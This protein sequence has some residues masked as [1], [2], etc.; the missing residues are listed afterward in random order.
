MNPDD[1]RSLRP[2]ESAQQHGPL[3]VMVVRGVDGAGGGADQIILRNAER[4]DPAQ[5]RMSLCFLRH[6]DDHE[7]DFDRRA[8]ALQLDYHEVRHR[9]ACDTRVWAQL[10]QLAEALQPQLIHSHEYKSNFYATCLA[11]HLGVPRLATAHGWTGD[12]WRERAVYY[13]GDKRL[14]R[15]FSGVIA[16]SDEIRQEL[17]RTG[18][19]AERIRVLLNGVDPEQYRRQSDTRRRVRG[20]LGLSDNH[21]VLGAVGRV[22]RQKR[23]DLLL[24]AFGDLRRDH[25][26]ARLVIAGEGSLLNALGAD[27]RRRGWTQIVHLLGHCPQML[28]TYQA[29]DVLVQSSDYEGTPTVIVEAMALEIPVVATDVGGTSQLITHDQH[30]LLVPRRRP[31]LLAQAIRQTLSDAQATA[32]RVAAA[33]HR[34]ETELNFARRLVKLQDIYRELVARGKLGIA[35]PD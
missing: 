10:R 28:Q 31:D 12:S 4:I 1:S 9:G 13:P 25:V 30:G 19:P 33:R 34:V 21:L 2:N 15:Y 7:F 17:I 29:F 14:L 24:D 23:F 11:R 16:V 22:E 32:R 26:D 6:Q 8:A 5:V 18:T 20:E 3:R 35:A 27:V